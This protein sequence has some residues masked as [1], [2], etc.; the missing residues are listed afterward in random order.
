MQE[1]RIWIA[2]DIAECEKLMPYLKI[3]NRVQGGRGPD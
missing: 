2:K 1:K 3:M